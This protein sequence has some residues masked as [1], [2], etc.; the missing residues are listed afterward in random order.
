MTS[1][2]PEGNSVAVW[3]WR[4]VASA[5][6]GLQ[7]PVAGSYTSALARGPAPPVTSTMPE[8]NSVAVW[9]WRAVAR[10]PVGLQVPVAGSYTSALARVPL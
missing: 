6:V 4:A 10:P 2:L 7:V 1:T 3:L 5:P 9:L 8:G